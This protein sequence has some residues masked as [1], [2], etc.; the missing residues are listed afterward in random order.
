MDFNQNEEKILS[1]WKEHAIHDKIREKNKAGKPYYFLDGPPYVS[2]ELHPGQIWVKV[3]KDALLRYKRMR[4]FNVH[5][6]AGYDVHGLPIE[7]KIELSMKM[8]SKKDITE[9]IG[10]EAFIKA[11]KEYTDS[12][13]PRMSRDFE[14][15]GVMLD[16]KNPYIPYKDSYIEEAWGMLKAADGKRLL[17]KDK[18][19]MPYCPK[20]ETV[21][22]QGTIE[23]TYAG[24]EDPSLLVKFRVNTKLS[25]PRIEIDGS[26]YLVIWTT[27][28]WTLPANVAVA[29]NPKEMYVKAKVGE[30]HLIM[31]KNRLDEVVNEAER[32]AVVEAE[33]YGSELEGIYYITPLEDLVPEQKKL[34]RKHRAVMSER[35]VS[36]NEGSGIVHVAPGHGYED[37]LVGREMKLPVFSPLDMHARYTAEAGSYQGLLVPSE[38][39]DRVIADL[40]ERGALIGMGKIRHSYPHC[41]RCNT[42]LLY[43]ATDQWFLNIQKIKKKLIRENSKVNWNPTEARLWQEEIFR[44]SPDWCISRQRYWGI[45]LP[46]WECGKCGAATIIGSKEEL[47]KLA[48]DG[49]LVDSLPTIHRP[50]VDAVRIRC[51]KCGG[52]A[53][54]IQDIFDVWFDS[55]IAFKASLSQ[56]EFER[57]YPADMITE[58]HDQ[59]RGW[60]STLMKSSVISYG[61]SPY[62]NVIVSGMML[63]EDSREM[64]K[65]LGNYVSIEDFL[66]FASADPFRLWSLGHTQWLDL[67]F[68][69]A[70]IGQARREILTLYNL[71]NLMD[72]YAD[73]IGYRPKLAKPR[74]VGKLDYEE[75]WILSRL[76]LTK[77]AATEGLEKYTVDIAV[78]KLGE[79]LVNDLS[80]FYIKLAKKKIL[81]RS[82]SI[83]RKVLD[84]LNYVLF[85]ML[86]MYAPLAPFAS[87]DIYLQ[88]YGYKESIFLE[89]WPK[90]AKA[91]A[92][93]EL[94]KSFSVATDAITA[95]LN[96]REKAGIRL[97]WPVKS[98]KLEVSSDEAYDAVERFS[99]VIKEYVNA[100]ELELKKGTGAEEEVR[101]NFAKLG[102]EFKGAASA[103]AEALKTANAKE[104]MNGIEEQGYYNLHTN[105]GT[106]PIKEEHFNIV[107]KL[108]EGD[109]VA[110]KYGTASVNPEVTEE[111]MEEALVREFERRVQLMRKEMKLRKSD[112]II[113]GYAAVGK[114]KHAIEKNIKDITAVLNISKLLPDAEG[115]LVKPFD[116]E[117]EEV[118][119]GVSKI[120]K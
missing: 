62:K 61:K 37:Y 101:P 112:K 108:E 85:N 71:A 82:K 90:P 4:G 107:K 52:E 16:F 11:C 93:A 19:P 13:M 3:R 9:K 100:K 79:F 114:I 96:S 65:S 98:A 43:L 48:V 89:D 39:N 88:R 32:N 103:I 53:A 51:P 45:P 36:V 120:K 26:T 46:I 14:R 110:F 31:A 24:E 60:F 1:Y 27:T 2:G 10:V 23:V 17:Y 69:K 42:K 54:R 34:R 38:A 66:K 118:K 41:W 18:K 68:N 40:K 87:E 113:L 58:G 115:E 20:C 94:E 117:E 7:H 99:E 109:A 35:L 97:R 102:P 104:L 77:A 91:L 64:H 21:L 57:L 12:L 106:F 95:I 15:F 5:D 55:G 105:M 72:E 47:R 116:I 44:N 83:A 33:F 92:N 49:N 8:G 63:A 81:Y 86:L 6:R 70:E 67:P 30:E 56:E 50:Y 29:V 75:A 84:T 78:N 119:V 76:E 73:A 111:L 74:N 80:R 28:P 59:L 25:K 22:A